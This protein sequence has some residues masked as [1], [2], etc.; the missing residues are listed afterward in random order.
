MPDWTEQDLDWV[1][2]VVETADRCGQAT[3]DVGVRILEEHNDYVRVQSYPTDESDEDTVESQG[4][5]ATVRIIDI[6]HQD[7]PY[8]RLLSVHLDGHEESVFISPH[9]WALGAVLYAVP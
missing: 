8:E 2:A 7:I 6:Q 1:K 4:V 9:G 3:Y 5:K